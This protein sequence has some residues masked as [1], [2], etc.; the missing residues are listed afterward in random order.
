MTAIATQIT[1]QLVQDAVNEAGIVMLVA[2]LGSTCLAFGLTQS[3]ASGYS[4]RA[5]V[6]TTLAVSNCG[7]PA[8]SQ[9][10]QSA[11]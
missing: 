10:N 1:E 6:R 5:S 11:F 3:W 8:V 2:L 9:P 7:T 4:P